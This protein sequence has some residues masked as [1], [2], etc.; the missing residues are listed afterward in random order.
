M[1]PS[2][3]FCFSFLT[4]MLPCQQPFFSFSIFPPNPADFTI[5]YFILL[6]TL[7]VGM[8]FASINCYKGYMEKYMANRAVE[9]L[10]KLLTLFVAIISVIN[11]I[12][13]LN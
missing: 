10:L 4:F 9:F 7:P 11:A 3:L 12:N 8:I 5:F 13:Y 1:I 6:I 2:I